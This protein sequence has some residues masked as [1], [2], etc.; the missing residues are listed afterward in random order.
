MNTSG[1]YMVGTIGSKGN[2][3]QQHQKVPLRLE[4]KIHFHLLLEVFCH[5]GIHLHLG[6]YLGL[7]VHLLLPKVCWAKTYY[8]GA[9]N[10]VTL[11]CFPGVSMIELQSW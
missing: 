5:L 4:S 7:E 2:L 1:G 11:Y 9:K 3:I 10:V 6:V 8:E